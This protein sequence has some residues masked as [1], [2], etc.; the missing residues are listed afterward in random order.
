MSDVETYCLARSRWLQ[1]RPN[2]ARWLVGL[3]VA[4]LPAQEEV[5]L[6]QMRGRITASLEE[7]VRQ[8]YGSP[9][10]V[11]LLLKVVVP[12]VVRLVLDWWSNRKE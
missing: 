3:A 10:L 5:D 7:S 6:G 11:W 2:D 8:R 12:I 1:S 4:Q 9:V